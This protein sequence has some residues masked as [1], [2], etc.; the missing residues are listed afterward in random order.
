[1]LIVTFIFIDKSAKDKNEYTETK[2]VITFL[3]QKY[4]QWPN[5]NFGKYRYLEIDNYSYPFEI[6]IGIDKGDFSPKFQNL[7]LLK[8]GDSIQVYYY[9]TDH[10]RLEKLNRFVQFIEKENILFYERGNSQRILGTVILMIWLL[11]LAFA[12]YLWKSGKIKF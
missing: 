6:F 9:E 3:G 8:I 11:L 4:E 5:R 12:T 7:D 10:T 1:M 2:G